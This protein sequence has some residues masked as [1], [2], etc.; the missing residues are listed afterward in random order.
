MSWQDRTL[1]IIV[2]TSPLGTMFEAKWANDSREFEKS[3]QRDKYPLINGETAYDLGSGADGYDISV[4]FDGVDC[5][6][7]AAKFFEASKE[8]GTW[9]VMHPVHG[10]IELQLLSIR[11]VVDPTSSGGFVVVETKWMEPLDPVTFQTMRQLTGAIDAQ[12]NAVSA[13]SA[14]AFA[15]SMSGLDFG[16]IGGIVNAINLVNAAINKIAEIAFYASANA[17]AKEIAREQSDAAQAQISDMTTA[18]AADP[19]D[20]EAEDMALAMH[21][22]VTGPVLSAP[23]AKT[24][25]SAMEDAIDSFVAVIPTATDKK[26]LQRAHVSEVAIEAAVCG[27]CLS[28]TLGGITTRTQAIATA[29][30]LSDLFDKAIDELDAIQDQFDGNIRAERRYYAQTE[31]F[32]EAFNLVTQTIRYLIAESY[33]LAI[34]KTITIPKDKTPL[35][36]CME[37]F[38]ATGEDRLGDFIN[39]NELEGDDLEIISG[40]REVVVY[41]E[42]VG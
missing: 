6:T 40:G 39:W 15:G 22:A 14:S 1:P 3:V 25:I 18:A 7:Q 41:V 20:F 29:Q 23:D 37:E 19:D 32:A 9:W 42:A 8:L 21:S 28:A 17:D 12:L 5:D 26:A 24:A 4:L 10:M 33:D 36:I 30:M 31:T 13:A 35:Q 11:H 27:S 38:G 16:A 2:L 34:E